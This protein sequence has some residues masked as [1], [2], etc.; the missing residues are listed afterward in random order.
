[1]SK[2]PV[3]AHVWLEMVFSVCSRNME[4]CYHVCGKW[5]A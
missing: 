1:M 3:M 2:P 5:E 4:G